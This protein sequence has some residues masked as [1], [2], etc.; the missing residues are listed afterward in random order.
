M[1]TLA[2]ALLE[3]VAY[4]NRLQLALLIALFSASWAAPDALQGAHVRLTAYR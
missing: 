2:E 4:P 1:A 3:T